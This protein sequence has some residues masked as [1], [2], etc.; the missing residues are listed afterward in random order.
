LSGL[1]R[2]EH[3]EL[4]TNIREYDGD[5]VAD[6]PASITTLDLCNPEYEQKILTE[7]LFRLASRLTLLSSIEMGMDDQVTNGVLAAF[8]S[9]PS[10]TRLS[11]FECGNV[12]DAGLTSLTRSKLERL[13]IRDCSRVTQQGVD[14]LRAARPSLEIVFDF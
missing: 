8:G 9:M 14:A 1:T 2:L 6:L 13:E 11:L 5:L 3:L 10:L 7:G 4:N 12:T